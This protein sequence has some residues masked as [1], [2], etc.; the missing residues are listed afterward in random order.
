MRWLL[1]WLTYFSGIY[2]IQAAV[3]KVPEIP[4][5]PVSVTQFYYHSHTS[6]ATGVNLTLSAQVR[7]TI[8]S[9]SNNYRDQSSVT[10]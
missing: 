4:F 2:L 6:V 7:A 10:L 1:I 3:Q 8:I 5:S 9:C